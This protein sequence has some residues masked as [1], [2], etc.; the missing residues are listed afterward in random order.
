VLVSLII[1]VSGMLFFSFLAD[2]TFEAVTKLVI[3]GQNTTSSVISAEMR[4]ESFQ[5]QVV[6]LNTHLELIKS[7]PVINSVIDPLGLDDEARARDLE[8]GFLRKILTTT[9]QNALKILKFR[10]PDITPQE[11]RQQL[12]ERI[13]NKITIKLVRD[14]KLVT[15][16][17]KDKQAERATSIANALAEKY[18]DFDLAKQMEATTRKLEWMQNELYHVKK[19]LEDEERK[20]FDFKQEQKIFSFKGKQDIKEQKIREV[21]EEFLKVKNERQQLD[22]IIEELS[23]HLAKSG[24]IANVRS[25]TNNVTLDK[26]YNTIVDLTVELNGLY[27]VYKSKHPIIIQKTTTLEKSK[28]R[29]KEELTK[30]IDNLYARRDMLVSNEKRL[31]QSIEDFEKDALDTSSKELSYIMLQRRVDENRNLY[32][33]LMDRIRESDL[34]KNS[35]SSNLRIVMPADVPVAPISPKKKKNVM[36][37][38]VG[39]LMFGLMLAFFSEYMDRSFRTEEELQMYLELPVLAVIPKAEPISL[40][41]DG[42]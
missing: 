16:S 26:L 1:A 40:D 17:V 29:F 23:R 39:G 31:L 18:I 34:L 7:D 27:N 10:K 20:F 15:I 9:K 28:N 33:T 13:K 21:N 8:V 24:Q 2:P 38:L 11:E 6:N 4:Y 12:I 5:S 35:G 22:A 36:I 37:G 19:K 14:T 41:G 30:E 25:L 42:T 3:E 32:D